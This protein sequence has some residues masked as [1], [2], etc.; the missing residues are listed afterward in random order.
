MWLQTGPDFADLTWLVYT[1]CAA[2]L[3]EYTSQAYMGNIDRLFNFAVD[4]RLPFHPLALPQLL[5]AV[6]TTKGTG[7]S[8][9]K[10]YYSACV[11]LWTSVFGITIPHEVSNSCLCF[12]RTVSCGHDALDAGP[13]QAPTPSYYHLYRLLEIGF[14][15]SCPRR[16]A[17]A[18]AFSFRHGLRRQD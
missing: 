4:N 17:F 3:A 8:T 6:N 2:D 10:G 16:R 15:S 7:P 18:A 13:T 14:R 5:A 1:A 9:L 11:W 12:I